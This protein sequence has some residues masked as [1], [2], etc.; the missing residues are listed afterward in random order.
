MT[1]K[2]TNLFSQKLISFG[3]ALQQI[4]RNL[5]TVNPRY[6]ENEFKVYNFEEIN[7]LF[8]Q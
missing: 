1:V 3:H 5:F 7:K 6:C 2:N 4:N 8:S